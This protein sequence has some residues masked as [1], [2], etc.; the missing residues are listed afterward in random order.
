ML[1]GTLLYSTLSTI[2]MLLS[3]RYAW[4]CTVLL[5]VRV[6]QSDSSGVTTLPDN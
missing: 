5:R 6:G 3:A 4:L 2:H 1:I